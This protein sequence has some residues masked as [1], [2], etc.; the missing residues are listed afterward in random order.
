MLDAAGDSPTH[1]LNDNEYFL[2]GDQ[3]GFSE[4][5]RHLFTDIQRLSLGSQT[6]LSSQTITILNHLLD[7]A[8]FHI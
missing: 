3:M 1:L 4:E 7:A 6:Y 2:I 8:S 5:D